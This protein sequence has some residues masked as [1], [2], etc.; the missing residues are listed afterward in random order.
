MNF[1]KK[2]SVGT[3]SKQESILLNIKVPRGNETKLIVFAGKNRSGKSHIINHIDRSIKEHNANGNKSSQDGFTPRRSSVAVELQDPNLSCKNVFLLND[4][5]Y[6]LKKFTYIPL[7]DGRITNDEASNIENICRQVLWEFIG[8]HLRDKHANEFDKK[9]WLADKSY[10][11]DYCANINPDKL[12]K[13]D[14]ACEVTRD[15]ESITNGHLYYRYNNATKNIELHLRYFDGQIFPNPSWSQGQRALFFYLCFICY[16]EIS[17]L[18]IDEVET[19]LHPQYI[20]FLCEKIKQTIPQAIV[21]THHPHVIF[22]KLID[23]CWYVELDEP[24]C[25]EPELE[26]DFEK[27]SRAVLPT[28]SRKIVDLESDFEKVSMTYKLF[29]GYDNNLL[30][31]SQSNSLALSESVL[32]SFAKAFNYGAVQHKNSNKPDLQNDKLADFIKR[33]LSSQSGKRLEVLDLGAGYG[34]T[35]FEVSKLPDVKNNIRWS[36]W[37]PFENVREELGK[38]IEQDSNNVEIIN[39]EANILT[40]YYDLVVISNVLHECNPND[41]AQIINRA[42]QAVKGDGQV[43]IIELYPLLHPEKYAVPYCESDM[44]VILRKS[45]FD[46]ESTSLNIKNSS[47]SAYWIKATKNPQKI[48]TSEGVKEAVLLQWDYILEN[49]CGDYKGK[50]EIT[51]P[52]H[53]VQVMG[54]LTTIASIQSFFLGQ[55]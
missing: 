45:G 53:V 14:G 54:E 22:S 18:L 1:I 35:F 17:I 10:R 43:V 11:F 36:F 5:D 55:W 9:K 28:F 4:L 51:E 38:L 49:T 30:R 42:A 23:Q 37:E 41:F 50:P 27:R 40:S 46:V 3:K 21:T 24:K 29:D 12:Y 47:V 19:Y 34:R 26:I 8:N 20:S 15:L 44:K 16:K 32:R 52:E 31:L 39:L 2:V 7:G 13:C 48:V 25:I 6:V 33:K